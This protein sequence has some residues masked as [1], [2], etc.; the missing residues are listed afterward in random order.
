MA[1]MSAVAA[2]V[3]QIQ[4]DNLIDVHNFIDRNRIPHDEMDGFD[5]L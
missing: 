5:G 1:R 2:R 4:Q 3:A